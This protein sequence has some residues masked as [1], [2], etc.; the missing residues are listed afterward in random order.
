MGA[1]YEVV[2]KVRD[3]EH[4]L[5]ARREGIGGSDAAAIL[6]VSRWASAIEIYAEKI[7][8]EPVSMDSPSDQA[9]WGNILEPHVIEE[10]RSRTG[11]VVKREGRLLRSRARPWQMATLDARQRKHPSGPPGL[12]EV[13]TTRFDWE[14]IPE[15]IWAQVQHQFA[16]T[17]MRYGSI[18]IFNRTSCETS[19]VDVEPDADYIGEMIE[20]EEK[21]WTDLCNG[22]PPA[23]DGSDSARATLR[24]LY[25][26][27]DEGKEIKLDDRL[28]EV[29]SSLESAKESR[30][31]IV[32][33]I[34]EYEND[35]IAAIGDAEVGL[36]ADGTRYTYRTQQRRETVQAATSFRVL[37]R[38]EAS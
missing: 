14:R 8:S 27:H 37:R 29:G 35:L 13:K 12:V 5:Q 26:E 2:A 7:S 17:K 28:I 23:P 10:F 33:E 38:K 22:K 11:R 34:R 19:I 36:L 31:K 1:S 16:V 9:R 25:P 4:W 3:R 21:F 32:S 15:D 30:K 6:G 24:S 18:V 20:L